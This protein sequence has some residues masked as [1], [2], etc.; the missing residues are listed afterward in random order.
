M[1]IDPE[2]RIM[3]QHGTWVTKGSFRITAVFHPALLLRDPSHNE[4]MLRDLVAIKNEIE[5]VD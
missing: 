3:K 4:A 2:Y 1:L 5:K